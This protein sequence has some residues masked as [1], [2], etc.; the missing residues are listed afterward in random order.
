MPI[1]P[2]LVAL[3]NILPESKLGISADDQEI[4]GKLSLA[5]SQREMVIM[6][7]RQLG[8][9]VSGSRSYHLHEQSWSSL[10][11]LPLGVVPPSRIHI[12]VKSELTILLDEYEVSLYDLTGDLKGQEKW[13]NYCAQTQGLVLFC[14]VLD[15]SDLV[16]IQ[17]AK[18]I[19]TLILANT[20]KKNAFLTCDIIKYLFFGK[21]NEI[22]I[23]PHAECKVPSCQAV[24]TV[25]STVVVE[26]C[27][28][29]KGLQKRKHHPLIDGLHWLL[30]VT[31][32][33]YEF[34]D[35]KRSLRLSP[36]KNVSLTFALDKPME[37]GECSRKN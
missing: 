27:S 20:D 16:H 35:K 7:P 1:C 10:T 32:D 15:S 22:R 23:C 5:S 3:T 31:E 30:A 8:F 11:P 13:P 24:S 18:I 17:E 26:P 14:F 25:I 19:L 4:E 28:A 2:F 21:A 29:I 34:V 36:Q 9:G 6:E 37:E 12:H 33:K